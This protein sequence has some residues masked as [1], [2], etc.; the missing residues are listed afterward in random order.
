MGERFGPVIGPAGLKELLA[1]N[2]RTRVM[3][4]RTPGE[5]ESVHIQGAYNVPLD[6]LSEHAG[7]IRANV[8]DPIVLVCQGGGRARKAEETLRAAGMP[9][10]HVLEG[11]M[12]AWLV[13]GGSV[14]RGAARLPL[15]RQVRIVTGGLCAIGGG[16]AL[17]VNPLFALVPAGVGSGLVFAGVT[18]SC[19]MAKL[20]AK[21][22]Y[23]RVA[24]CDVD[25]MVRALRAGADPTGRGRDHGAMAGTA[26][27]C[28]G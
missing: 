4:V 28:A 24:T 19:L 23:N 27:S 13:A 14:V 16:L 1:G 5:Y 12:Q 25:A 17:V 10:L 22:P 7:E 3:D 26:A 11:G 6:S 20:L 9:N 18:D 15:E 2:P 21:L 8:S